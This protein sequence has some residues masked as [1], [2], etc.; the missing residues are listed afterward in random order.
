MRY[1]LLAVVALSLLVSACDDYFRLRI[2]PP[3]FHN[4]LCGSCGQQ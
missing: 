4:E 1:S 3:K 2:E